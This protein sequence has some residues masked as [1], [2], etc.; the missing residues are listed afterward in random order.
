MGKASK[1]VDAREM[2]IRKNFSY[3]QGIVTSMMSDHAGQTALIRKETLVGFFDTPG[4]AVS[5][6]NKLF[7]DLPFSVQR[8]I[9]R[10]ID[11]GFLSHAADSG[12][13]I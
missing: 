3:F 11:L 13:S 7:G 4:E 6:G 12:V 10:P 8:V 9:D 2:E 1:M 5:E